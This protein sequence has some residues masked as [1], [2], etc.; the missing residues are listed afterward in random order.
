MKSRPRTAPLRPLLYT[1]PETC[2]LLGFESRDAVYDRIR[3]GQLEA[4]DVAAEGSTR[5]CLRVPAAS[6]DKFIAK[7]P[8]VHP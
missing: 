4:V 8:R 1:I 7:L 5:T 6:I 2:I 3:D